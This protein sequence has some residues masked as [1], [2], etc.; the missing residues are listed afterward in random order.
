MTAKT[1][2][3]ALERWESEGGRVPEA[4]D[5]PIA[6]QGPIVTDTPEE[7]RLAFE[8]LERKTFVKDRE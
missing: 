4:V 1:D 7:L 6:R 2:A 8:A 5:E 3:R